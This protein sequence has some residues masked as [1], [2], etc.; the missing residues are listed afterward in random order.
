MAC[1][2]TD[3]QPGGYIELLINTS[4]PATADYSRGGGLALI[5]S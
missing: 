1:L 5:I 2:L 3:A 4:D